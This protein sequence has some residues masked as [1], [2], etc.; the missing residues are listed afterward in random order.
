MSA[1]Q[2][3]VTRIAAAGR[4]VRSLE[5]AGDGYNRAHLSRAT[6]S[7]LLEQVARGW[8]AAPGAVPVG[9]RDYLQV[10]LRYPRAAFH[11]AAAAWLLEH[12]DEEPADL[13]IVLPRSQGWPSGE[14]PVVAGRRVRIHHVADHRM[15]RTA[16]VKIAGHP[17][18]VV[19]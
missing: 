19:T 16:T 13:E 1:I 8:Y 15:P 17:V 12:L 7:G 11:G 9:R 18:K 14:Q 3:L 4:P 6:A 10:A 2:N 5:L